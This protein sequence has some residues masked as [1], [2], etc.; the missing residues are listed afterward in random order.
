MIVIGV[1]NSK[2]GVGKTTLTA[3]LAVRAARDGAAAVVDLDPQSSYSD[4]YAR[5]GS[6][7]NP[8]LLTGEERASDA[9]EALSLNSP[10]QFVFLDGPPGSLTV[11]KDAVEV[12][13]LVLIPMR[14]SGLDLA[15][16]QDCVKLCLDTGT[17]FLC[18][19]NAV[20]S[21]GAKTLTE[22]ARAMLLNWQIPIASTAIT[23]RMQFINAM[24]LGKTGPEKDKAAA[25]EIDNLWAEVKKAALAAS[26]KKGGT[27]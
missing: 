25:E 9:I 14:T 17:P 3:C 15:A 23:H 1:L 27:T 2:G 10:Y 20:S 4:W 19:F 26:N 18:V 21:R 12:C 8:A 24:T 7:D 5:R 6:P 11:T 22:S 13:T 16:S